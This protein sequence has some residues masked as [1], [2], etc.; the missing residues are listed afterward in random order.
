MGPSGQLAILSI[1]NSDGLGLVWNHETWILEMIL[2][3]QVEQGFSSHFYQNKFKVEHVYLNLWKII[4]ITYPHRIWQRKLVREEKNL[5]QILTD[6]GYL[7]F[8]LPILDP[9]LSE[10][11]PLHWIVNGRP[12]WSHKQAPT[13][14][15]TS[16]FEML[17]CGLRHQSFWNGWWCFSNNP[18]CVCL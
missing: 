3:R 5:L 15:S 7:K 6:F 14:I 17:F 1:E 16:F 4:I 18:M 2:S 10:N 9:S 11:R 8:W 12:G 13:Y